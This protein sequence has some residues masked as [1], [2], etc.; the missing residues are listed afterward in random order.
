MH[1]LRRRCL[2]HGQSQL[3]KPKSLVV[4]KQKVSAKQVETSENKAISFVEDPKH[5]KRNP[6]G[7]QLLSRTL[8]AQLFPPS[9]SSTTAPPPPQSYTHISHEHLST[10]GLNPTLASTLPSTTFT[11]PPLQGRSIP[12]HFHRVGDFVSHPYRSL[13]LGLAEASLPPVPESGEWDVTRSGWTRYTWKEGGAGWCE[14]VP[15]PRREQGEEEEMLVFDVETMPKEGHKYPVIAVAAS[16]SAWYAWISPWLLGESDEA[17]HLIPLSPGGEWEDKK[18]KLVVGHNVSFDRARV[19]DEYTVPRLGSD[20][21]HSGSKIRWLDTMSLHVAVNGISSHQRPAWQKWKKGKMKEREMKDE[22]V[23]VVTELVRRVREEEEREEG[24]DEEKLERLRSLRRDMEE[25]LNGTS[26]EAD[27]LEPNDLGEEKRWESLTSANSLVDVARLHC[28]IDVEDEKTSTRNRL[29]QITRRELMP[30][31]FSSSPSTVAETDVEEEEEDLYG[32]ATASTTP[33]PHLTLADLLTY[34]SKDVLIT[35]KIFQSVL[36]SFLTRCPHPVSFSGMLTMGS[37]FLTVNQEWERYIHNAERVYSSMEES[38]KNK[39]AE[40]ARE[41]MQLAIVKSVVKNGRVYEV[42]WEEDGTSRWRDDPWLSQ[43][44][45]TPKKAAKSRGVGVVEEPGALEKERESQENHKQEQEPKWYTT[46]ASSGPL[47]SGSVSQTLPLLLQLSC[48]GHPLVYSSK[49]GWHYRESDGSAVW[50]PTTI[51]KPG[52]PQRRAT[53]VLTPRHAKVLLHSGAMRAGGRSEV[54]RRVMDLAKHVLKQRKENPEQVLGDPWLS[55]L[56]WSTSASTPS[57][58]SSTVVSSNKASKC[59][60]PAVYWPKWYWD[61]T[62]PKKG[63]APGTID[64]S[65]RNRIAPLLLRLAWRGYPLCFSREH[66]W[67]YRVPGSNTTEETDDK[68][69]GTRP[70]TFSHPADSL[71]ADLTLHHGSAFHKLPHK[72]GESANVGS[73]LG[74]TFVQYAADGTL[75]SPGGE[76]K[77]ALELNAVCSYWISSRDRIM[78]QMVVWDKGNAEEDR[79]GVILPQVI[80]MGTVTRRAIEKTWLTA[81]NAK[82]NRVGSEL[83]A[84]VRA[85]PGYAIVG[86]DVDSEELWISSCLGDAQFGMHGATALGWMTLEGTKSAGTD[87]HS[88]TAKILGLS[89]DQAKVFNYSRIYGAGMKHA[90][91]LL[92]QANAG[93]MSVEQARRLAENLYASTKGKNTHR[94]DVF[95][96]KFWFGGSESFVFNKLEEIANSEQPKTPALGCGVTYAL[97]REYLPSQFG[98]DYMPSRINWVVQSSGVDY[99]HMLIVSMDY[100]IARYGI[101]AR[102]LISVHDE[103]RYLVAEQ[104]KFRAA[105]ALQIANLWTRAMFAYMLGMDDLP[106]GVAFFSAVD[107]DTCLRKEVDMECVTPSQPVPIPPGESLGIERVLEKTGGSLGPV[108]P[109]YGA[110]GAQDLVGSLEGYQEPACL[111]HRCNSAAFLRAQATEDF[112]E[113]KGLAQQVYGVK[114]EG[115]IGGGGG[116]GSAGNRSKRQKSTK[117]APL[118]NGEDVDWSDAVEEVLRD[119]SAREGNSS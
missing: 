103:L 48:N 51:P 107:V 116:G 75:T 63:L 90:V 36:P 30:H 47:S 114:F 38:V 111:A 86:A 4:N 43:L 88:K 102:Y 46:L 119:E 17:D 68:S 85:P 41:K 16:P 83:K 50:L 66:G 104:D 101:Q 109:V 110:S 74:K 14:A 78:N 32:D 28:N 13:A 11:L 60:T 82:K 15:Y 29:L 99:L 70:L 67:C 44:D 117:L 20:L 92:L 5:A 73:P 106:Q 112:G 1:P 33:H 84:M 19:K 31:L 42:E 89:R 79:W 97:S 25:S 80:A 40:L 98:S 64:L 24:G 108:L 26:I 96:R 115:G 59:K 21:V 22:A 53:T 34:C 91:L 8:H 2:H 54:E 69:G 118:G 3:V 61:L 56:D 18:H 9:T 71:L 94:T 7:V 95:E 49:D 39:L 27:A 55:Q 57:S 87:L 100:L 77:E 93:S 35:H 37:S 23:Q 12:E 65:P 52:G 62:K 58:S 105:L 76:A 113:V 6:L 72:D 10:H 45:W 81:S